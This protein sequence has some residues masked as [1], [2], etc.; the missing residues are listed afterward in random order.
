M[1]GSWFPTNGTLKIKMELPPI[2]LLCRD[3]RRTRTHPAGTQEC[4][5]PHFGPPPDIRGCTLPMNSRS[6]LVRSVA[7][8]ASFSRAP[9]STVLATGVA[10][11]HSNVGRTPTFQAPP[12]LAPLYSLHLRTRGVCTTRRA[13]SE[14]ELKD[15]PKATA[16]S[17]IVENLE[18]VRKRVVD[19]AS[20]GGTG[21]PLPRLVAV[22]KTKPLEDLQAAYEAG[23]RIFG[24][25]Y[26]SHVA[27]QA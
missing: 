8:L 25:N 6:S 12:S 16:V 19:V 10:V 27:I 13:M 17:P 20:E 22:S 1:V 26:V 15:E 21:Q 11:R 18:A 24:E 9:H 5:T 23:Q 14:A 4:D 3:V 2:R 7:S